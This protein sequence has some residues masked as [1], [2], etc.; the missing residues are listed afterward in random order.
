[1]PSC[2]QDAPIPALRNERAGLRQPRRNPCSS[3]GIPLGSAPGRFSGGRHVLGIGQ[4]PLD[5]LA[6]LAY[7]IASRTVRLELQERVQ[8]PQQRGVVALANVDVG[9]QQME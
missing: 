2:P 5:F 9:Q 1:M 4:G 6:C 3:Y 7:L 8:I